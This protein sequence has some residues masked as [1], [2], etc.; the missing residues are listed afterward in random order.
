MIFKVREGRRPEKVA[1]SANSETDTAEVMLMV[2]VSS[3]LGFGSLS[4]LVKS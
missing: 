4:S 3:E 2:Q 1:D